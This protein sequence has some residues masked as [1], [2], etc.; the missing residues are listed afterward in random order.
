MAI[1]GNRSGERKPFENY[2]G[3]FFF[4]LI[5]PDIK[6]FLYTHSLFFY[7]GSNI[8]DYRFYWGRPLILLSLKLALYF[9]FF[10]KIAGIFLH[11]SLDCPNL[12]CIH[13]IVKKGSICKWSR[14]FTLCCSVL[15]MELWMEFVVLVCSVIWELRVLI[16]TARFACLKAYKQLKNLLGYWIVQFSIKG[17][18]IKKC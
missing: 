9:S 6:A 12:E 16:I 11:Q 17:F 15:W 3:K 1:K 7:W 2:K 10:V 5:R 18:I 4:Y 14:S 13:S 8:T